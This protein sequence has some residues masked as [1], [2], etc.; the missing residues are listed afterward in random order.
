[1]SEPFPILTSPSGTTPSFSKSS[2]HASS[3][4]DRQALELLR[5]LGSDEGENFLCRVVEM[6]FNSARVQLEKMERAVGEGDGD[7]LWQ[8]AHALK[9]SSATLGALNLSRLC[10]EL[11]RRGRRGLLQGAEGLLTDLLQEYALVSRALKAECM[12]S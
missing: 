4:L 12:R 9:S 3:P 11:E 2:P 7:A 8:V 10:L 6:F 5:E 1:M